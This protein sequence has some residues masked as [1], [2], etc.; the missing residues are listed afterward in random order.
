MAQIG[1]ILKLRKC[2]NRREQRENDLF[3][4]SEHQNP[5][6][7]RDIDVTFC[8]SAP[9]H[10]FRFFLIRKKIHKIY[11]NVIIDNFLKFAKF[12]TF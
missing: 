1:Q 9:S 2:R 7:F 8:T 3:R 12:S 11:E 5:V 6:I 4:P 10:I